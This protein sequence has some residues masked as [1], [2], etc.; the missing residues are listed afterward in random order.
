MGKKNYAD[1][2]FMYSVY[3]ELVNKRYNHFNFPFLLPVDQNIVP[4]YYE[5]IKKPIDLSTIK[6]KLD[7]ES[8]ADAE[9]FEKDGKLFLF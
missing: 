1:F 3:R 9:D 8:Y 4:G 2:K 7:S 6:K 5:A